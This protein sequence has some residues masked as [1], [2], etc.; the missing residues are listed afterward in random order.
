MKIKGFIL[1]PL[2]LLLGMGSV[3]H[4]DDCETLNLNDDYNSPFRSMPVYDQDGSGTCYAHAAAQMVN[5]W[6]IKK[7]EKDLISPIYA[8][9]QMS[10]NTGAKDTYAGFSKT[11]VSDLKKN[12][13]CPS[14]QVETCLKAWKKTGGNLTDA[15]LIHFFEK[16]Y[17]NKHIFNP[18]WL[19]GVDVSQDG[20]LGSRCEPLMNHVRKNE[21]SF[22]YFQTSNEILK[23]IFKDCKPITSLASIPDPKVYEFATFKVKEKRIDESLAKGFPVAIDMCNTIRTNQ[24]FRPMNEKNQVGGHKNAKGEK[25]CNYHAVLVTARKKIGNACSYLVR[26]SWG[27]FDSPKGIQ[28]ACYLKSGYYNSNCTH[29]SRAKEIKEIVGC[30]YSK[31][32]LLSNTDRVTTL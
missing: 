22:S 8:A 31:E 28:C 11:V 10:N 1:L 14:K 16:L 24:K 7:G 20:Y 2:T 15:Q 9:W 29:P 27:A 13:Y 19:S 5:Y 3:S 25:D 32:D 21:I 4:A 23:S 18:L 30:W 6:R 12:G 26:N 17:K